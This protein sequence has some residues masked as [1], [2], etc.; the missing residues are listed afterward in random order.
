MERPR[1]SR[2]LRMWV[3]LLALLG[4]SAVGVAQEVGET[5]EEQK[6]LT[7]LEQRMQTKISVDFRDT[8]IDDVIR[9]IAKQAETDIVKSP[10]VTGNV[11]ATLTDVP[12]EEALH[13]ILAAHGYAFVTSENMMR[14]VPAGEVTEEMEN[15]VTRV[16]RITYADVKNVEAALTKFL[17]KR[18]TI[19][20]NVGTSN[21]IVTDVESKVKSID[22]FV[23]EI[24][25]ITPQVMV[26]ARVY[27]VTS[28]DRFELG[29]EWSA[30]T[31]TTFNADTGL[32]EDGRRDPF[33][34][35]AFNSAIT[36]TDAT[37]GLMRFGIFNDNVNLDAVLSA[38]EENV[39]ATL[40]ASPRVLVL[41]NESASIKIISEIPYQQLTQ[42]A[43]GGN[44]GTT[45]FKEVGVE[46]HVT[47]HVCREGM[48][49]LKL[50]PKFSIAVGSVALTLPEIAGGIEGALTAPQPVIDTREEETIALIRDGEVVVI[51]GLH[52]KEQRVEVSKVPLLGDL[53]LMGALFRYEGERTVNS[54]LVVFIRPRIV[55]EDPVM[56]EAE[57]S[58]LE[59]T[60]AELCGPKCRDARADRCALHSK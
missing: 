19:S 46:L 57:Q 31:Q 42:T 35:G 11:T 39:C 20:S 25:R 30:G 16:Y 26:E 27:D 8:P 24:D 9:I 58:Q 4:A 22:I 50:R 47:P 32:P 36:E 23:A 28:T 33:F 55:E 53:P 3:V 48:I 12:L 43:M 15:L 54:E 1:M 37:T 40:L 49:R 6:P 56:T 44:I 2:K 34:G 13:H 17:S 7:S 51:G 5:P 29:I 38:E 41:D 60:Q 52:K 10:K 45:E 18:G 14:I 21:I 59:A